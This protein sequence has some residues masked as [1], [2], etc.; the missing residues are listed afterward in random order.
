[1]GL[2][3]FLFGVRRPPP[4]RTAKPKRSLDSIPCIVREPNIATTRPARS[5]TSRKDLAVK[6]KAPEHT[7]T[8]DPG[9]RQNV[10]LPRTRYPTREER[11]ER[12]RLVHAHACTPGP[13]TLRG[14][15]W[16][17]D[18]DTIVIDHVH[19]RL[20]GIDAP[21]LDQPYGK[22]SKWALV[23]MTKGQYVTANV[24]PE[25]S[26]DRVVARCFLPDG[27]DLAAE[28]VKQGLALD[29]P[30]FS[31]GAYKTFE[32]EGVRKKLWKTACRQPK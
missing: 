13:T 16:V 22:V 18:G 23:K 19:I 27:R 31:K 12:A 21:E 25:M 32:P 4:P 2:F 17:I 3:N 26:F 15:C 9:A 6:P 7:Y 1:M 24:V 5:R 10:A 28:M 8:P 29:W 20:A 14:K 30:V 11:G